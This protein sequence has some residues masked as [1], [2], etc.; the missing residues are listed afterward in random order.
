M[1]ILFYYRES[2]SIGIEYLMALLKQAGHE[3]GLLFEQGVSAKY[4]MIEFGFLKKLERKERLIEYAKKFDPDLIAFSSDYY[5]YPHVRQV[6]KILK[7]ILRVPTI[8]GG[9]QATSSPENVLNDEYVD[10][11]CIGEGE[12]AILELADVMERGKEICNI[13]NIWIKKN[14]NITR[15]PVRPL[16]DNL[17]NLPFPD[18]ELFFK[19]NAFHENL[20]II[21]SRGCP[22]RCSF[23]HNPAEQDYYKH[24][25]RFLRR[26]SVD[27]VLNE[28][29]ECI[30]KYQI[31][32]IEFEDEI[33]N[34]NKNWFNEFCDKY[35]KE[36]HLPF[37][38][39]LRADT[40]TEDVVEKLKY[41]GCV[42]IFMGVESGN[43]YIRN[44][45]LKK[46]LST[47]SIINA[48]RLIKE[49]NIRLQ[50]TAM[51]AIPHETDKEM[52][53]TVNL[54]E[55]LEA[56][57]IPTY[58]LFPFPKTPILK[59]TF[60]TGYLDE[61]RYQE[62][63]NGESGVGQTHG[64]SVLNHHFAPLAY[65]ISKLLSFY[66]LLPK[67]IRPLFKR[68]FF[69]NKYIKG[70]EAIYN[71]FLIKN[72]RFHSRERVKLFVKELTSC[73]FMKRREHPN[74]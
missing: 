68:Y 38:C 18:R 9:I 6:A 17:D 3:I 33:F 58:T 41:A 72:Y 31:K 15:M 63:L 12:E 19:N 29:K 65:N 51:F 66:L 44:K 13:E 7:D 71:F 69:V 36:I 11:I 25:R 23:C 42:E 27:N 45:I 49:Y 73:I 24:S 52:Y 67:I 53:D 62:I 2:E 8:M 48:A 55:K 5:L 60:E 57:S 43:E 37:W 70:A 32:R 64:V 30:K 21:S 10:M 47:A 74:A 56:D 34:I 61:N 59:Y 46:N 1:K 20:M 16:I 54:L 26:R 50:A 35:S 22:Y 14:G 4:G 39:Q 28:I 40:V